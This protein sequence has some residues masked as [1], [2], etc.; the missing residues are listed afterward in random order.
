MFINSEELSFLIWTIVA[1]ERGTSGLREAIVTAS[2]MKA[3]TL[4]LEDYERSWAHD[5]YEP[6]YH[7]VDRIVLRSMSDDETYD[8][9][10]PWHPLS[11]VRQVLAVLPS[12]VQF[13]SQ[14]P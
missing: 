10:F 12:A 7:G 2:L 9:Q 6:G 5:P 1:G 13:D 4:T 11:K 14:R 8:Q 3:G